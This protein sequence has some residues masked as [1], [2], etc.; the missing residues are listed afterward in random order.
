VLNRLHTIHGNQLL[1]KELFSVFYPYHPDEVALQFVA[2]V[3]LKT[4]KKAQSRFEPNLTYASV[5]SSENMHRCF[6]LAPHCIEPIQLEI[7]IAF[8]PVWLVLPLCEDIFISK[9]VN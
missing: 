2:S 1:Y 5:F 6:T 4:L 8:C 7:G 3:T 9:K